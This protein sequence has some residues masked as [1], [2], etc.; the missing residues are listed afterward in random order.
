MERDIRTI[1]LTGMDQSAYSNSMSGEPGGGE[2]PR[3]IE[4]VNPGESK[5]KSEASSGVESAQLPTIE[6]LRE[7]AEASDMPVEVRRAALEQIAEE[8]NFDLETGQ[9]RQNTIRQELPAGGEADV[10][11]QMAAVQLSE[12]ERLE[13]IINSRNLG[14]KELAEIANMSPE[15]RDEFF[16][17]LF[18]TL[19]SR[20]EEFSDKMFS[21]LTPSGMAYD[22]FITAIGR[23]ASGIDDGLQYHTFDQRGQIIG[24]E[25]VSLPPDKIKELAADFRRYQKEYNARLVAHDVTA[26]LHVQGLKGEQFFGYVD[27]FESSLVDMIYSFDGIR[28]MTDLYEYSLRESMAMNDG[29][30][31]PEKLGGAVHTTTESGANGDKNV[32]HVTESEID[33]RTKELF[34]QLLEGGMIKTRTKDGRE[35]VMSPNE[36]P[37]WKVERLFNFAKGNLI[38][39][40]RLISIAAES[41]LPKGSARFASGSLQDIEGEYARLRHLNAKWGITAEALS[42]YLYTGTTGNVKKDRLLK[43]WNPKELK[44]MWDRYHDD[45]D[46]LL[47]NLEHVFYLG[48]VNPNRAGDVWT[49]MSWRADIK[50]TDVAT[51][52]QN[53]LQKGQE[54][55]QDRWD[56]LYSGQPDASVY[57]AFMKQDRFK[58]EP[59]SDEEFF[60]KNEDERKRITK[61]R[62]R[63]LADMDKEWAKAHPGTIGISRYIKFRDEYKNW[64][65]TG[66]RFEK[67]RGD[68]EKSIDYTQHMDQG[69]IDG[70]HRDAYGLLKRMS[71][72]Q[73]HRLYG[74][75]EHVRER[76]TGK[77]GSASQE[78]KDN[79]QTILGDMQL[80]ESTMLNDRER[81]LDMGITF[82]TVDLVMMDRGIDYFAQAIRGDI[83]IKDKNGNV[84]RVITRADRIRMA[85]E[86]A[87]KIRQDFQDREAVHFDAG[88]GKYKGKE[89][90]V[91]FDEFVTKREYTHGYVLWSGDVPLDEYDALA[92][93]TTGAYARRGRDNKNQILAGDAETKLLDNLKNIHNVEDLYPYIE[94][95]FGPIDHYDRGKAQQA[96]AEKLYG[97]LRFYKADTITK[98]P[99]AGLLYKMAARNRVSAAQM[100]YGPEAM[101][102]E[103]SD[104]HK[105]IRHFAHNKKITHEQEKWLMDGLGGTNKHLTYELGLDATELGLMAL[106]IEFMALTAREIGE[107]IKES[108]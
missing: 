20:P 70:L 99:V 41:N 39:S 44:D 100:F 87:G 58:M 108:V 61:A 83:E 107:G 15:A 33:I 79:I 38:A 71:E 49:W 84:T 43:R 42:A 14:R 22:R 53:Y 103:S 27:K 74:V 48:K 35:V 75:S 52:L 2:V 26:I 13:D 32:T 76:I 23:L 6:R 3:K 30:L 88:K 66:F 65:G 40:G 37:Q 80:V 106:F 25:T 28:Q 98:V 90:G 11:A 97:I 54:K 60:G 62:E 8:A 82:N 31:V 24:T 46:R 18:I 17:N 105:V 67:M 102:L 104:I 91:Y 9:K 94:E 86:F 19:D 55:M 7:L 51:M 56:R 77:N 4:G 45:P 50:D 85:K 78:I 96:V 92:V 59:L 63:K 95:I 36:M 81:L 29:V 68:L 16:N 10:R 93:G 12:S 89:R 47:R 69:K 73:G 21:A 34:I 57:E 64:T 101:A 72:L 1:Q 5:P